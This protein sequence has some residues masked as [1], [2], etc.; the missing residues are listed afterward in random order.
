[1]A[2]SNRNGL[3]AGSDEW[4]C[5]GVCGGLVDGEIFTRGDSSK[6]VGTGVDEVDFAG[7]RGEDGNKCL[8][9]V[10]SAEDGD[11]PRGCGTVELEEEGHFSATGHADVL[12][13][14]PSD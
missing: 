11:V 14:I 1:M 8:N 9:D 6:P 2:F 12:L 7:E 13:E 5:L 3:G 10:A 4:D